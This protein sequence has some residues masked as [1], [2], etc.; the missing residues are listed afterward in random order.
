VPP[1]LKLITD[2]I[3]GLAPIP[4][5]TE[6][7]SALASGVVIVTSR[8]DDR[9]WGLT[10]TSFASV[11]ADPPTVLVS[12]R[13]AGATAR[14]IAVARSFG[15][16]ILSEEQLAVARYGS[17]PGAAKYLE[18]FGDA[19]D[20]HSATPAVAGALAHL[21]CEVADTVRVSDHTVFFGRVRTARAPNAGRP[22]LYHRRNYPRLA[23]PAA[24]HPSTERSRTWLTN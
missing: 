23:T 11:S 6:A 19:E 17:E 18:R 13:S 2:P 7:M 4:E 22:L 16:S 21:E 20:D 15:V 8:V 5:F 14:S 24:A 10:V 9:P 1:A 12:L 3:P